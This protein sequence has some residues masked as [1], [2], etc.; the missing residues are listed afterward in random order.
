M[1]EMSSKSDLSMTTERRFYEPW[2]LPLIFCEE[3]KE[4]TCQSNHK[5]EKEFSHAIP[6]RESKVVQNCFDL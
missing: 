3:H 6:K 1:C 2:Y 4:I 5:K